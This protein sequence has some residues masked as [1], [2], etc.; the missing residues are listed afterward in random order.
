M[1]VSNI[2]S[3]AKFRQTALLID[4]QSTVLD[5]HA[6]IIKSLKMNL[7]IVK[8]TDP[9]EALEWMKNKQVD[10]IITDFRMHQM[11]GMQF[12]Q[13]IKNA[14]HDLWR[15]IIVVT[16]L[17]DESIHQELIT[18]GVA[19]CLTKPA[20]TQELATIAKNLLEK[21][22]HHYSQALVN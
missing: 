9:V 11:N 8:M 18:A 3:A 7:K 19:A 15:S 17:K 13:A 5:I 14:G 21:S 12:V 1:S 6:A 20:Q 16:A 2:R 4:D 22:K 10:L